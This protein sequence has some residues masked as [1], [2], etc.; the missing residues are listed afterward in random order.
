[1]RGRKRSE[2]GGVARTD[3]AIRR[4]H[5]GSKS[6]AVSFGIA[7]VGLID[8]CAPW[9]SNGGLYSPSSSPEAPSASAPAGDEGAFI[10]LAV[11]GHNPAIVSLPRTA[12]S[13]R[14]LL[15]ASHGAGDRAEPHCQLW[16]RIIDA[17][18]FVLCPQGRRTDERVPHAHAAYYYPDHFA[19]DRELRAA[20]SALR[21][22][23]PDLLDADRAVYAGFS[24]GAIHG[25]GIIVLHP[26]M[27]PRAALVEGGNGFFNEWSAYAARKYQA[28]GGERVLFACG[29]PACVRTADNCAA[30]L[31]RAG[32][33]Q[34]VVHA[35]GAGHSYGAL[36]EIQLRTSF[37]WLVA[38]DSRWARSG[39]GAG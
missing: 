33:E 27:F 35:P 12:S 17:H 7:L 20:I 13:P 4:Y 36:M 2:R 5:L 18:A 25:A 11:S 19:L 28:G 16:R 22:R 15:V 10:E 9:R 24:Q 31:R 32:V 37:A 6:G 23:Y 1:M 38:G 29:S 8:G 14:P 21:E 39:G 34:R 26:E 30:H 3:S